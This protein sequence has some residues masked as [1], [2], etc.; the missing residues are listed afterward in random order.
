VARGRI[1]LRLLLVGGVAFL[2]PSCPAELSVQ[3][4]ELVSNVRLSRT[5]SEY[6]YRASVANA[7]GDARN[8]TAA[9]S[10]TV[11]GV[12]VLDGNLA[13]GDVPSGQ[14]LGACDTFSVLHDRSYSFDESAF[15]WQVYE[16][17]ANATPVAEAGPEQG[18]GVGQEITL[19]GSASTDVD[20]DPLTYAWS[21]V[22]LPP[23]SQAA[24]SDPSSVRPHFQPDVAG[25]YTL[26]LVVSDGQHS[27]PPDTLVV[28]TDDAAPAAHAGPDQTVPVGG[29]AMLDG[30]AS[31]DPDGDALAYAWEIVSAPPG[32][33]AALS[34][35]A[36]PA[37][38]F[39]VD[40]AGRYRIQLVVDD[41]SLA[42]EADE[43]LVDTD[44]SRPSAN[45]GPAQTV[46]VGDVV[47]LDGSASSDPDGAPLAYRWSLLTWPTG[48]TA[49]LADADTAHPS[50][51]ADAEGLTI[52]QLIVG[53][54]CLESEPATVAVEV[55]PP[56]DSDG[57]GLTD[58]EEAALGTD[59]GN[60]D[61]DG[62]GLGDGA[63]VNVHHTNPLLV[64]T[65]GDGFSDKA[66]VDA[67]SDPN[68]PRDT[69]LG[70]LPPDPAQ[71]APPL[72]DTTTT[73]LADATSFLYEGSDPV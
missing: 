56:P 66:E 31:V 40:R 33:A 67:G 9:L 57:D 19:D 44:D 73:S 2:G 36:A 58:A 13:F 51:I 46:Y 21:I 28:S 70:T 30:S 26:Q 60:P 64:D 35:P 1:T 24:L 53:D 42:S 3:D 5:L 63:E 32:S 45:P 68:A 20:G 61:T 52:A 41:G 10:V 23:G 27:S 62:D 37:P 8:V 59:P 55:L 69:P 16:A 25:D 22:S 54:G 29:L 48:S 71:V 14:T 7:D 15:H 39:T 43:V 17:P 65:D 18:A 38:S 6:T 12:T 4:Y 72:D 11:P 34:D 47:A 49:V 50:F